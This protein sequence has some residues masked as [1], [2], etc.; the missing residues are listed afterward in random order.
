M[1][2]HLA[3]YEIPRKRGKKYYKKI[4]FHFFDL[5]LWNSFVLYLK[6]GGTK[7]AL[8]FRLDIVREILEKYNSDV[9]SPKPGRPG[10][11]PNPLRLTGRHFPEFL[12]ATDKKI[13]PTRQCAMCSRVRDANGKRIRRESRYYCPDCNVTLCVAPCFRVYHTVSN[14]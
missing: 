7:T 10:T 14:I 3:D 1:D 5:A 6:N 2:Q 12:P 13:N 4:F 9:T 11:T 8:Q